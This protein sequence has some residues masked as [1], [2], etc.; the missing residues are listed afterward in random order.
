MQLC[1]LFVLRWP[2]KN[3]IRLRL[4]LKKVRRT[5]APRMCAQS[6]ATENVVPGKRARQ[7]ADLSLG[8]S[9]VSVYYQNP[10]QK[11]AVSGIK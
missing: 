6:G 2:A 3:K 1:M 4:Q 8:R 7:S 9:P 10:L 11:L 5:G